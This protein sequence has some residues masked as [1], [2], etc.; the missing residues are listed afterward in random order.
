MIFTTL[1]DKKIPLVSIGTSPF[2]GAGQFGP[3]ALLWRQKFLNNPENVSDLLISSAENGGM[4]IEIVPVGRIAEAIAVVQKKFPNFTVTG[5]TYWEAPYRIDKLNDLDAEIIFIHGA[6]AD[7]RNSKE[8]RTIIQKIRGFNKIPGIATHNP[9][10]T[11]PFIQNSGL[12]C[13]A[14]LVP[15]NK[16]GFFMEHQK[17]LEDIVDNSDKFFV[18]MKSLAAGRIKPEEAYQYIKE[19]NI[20]AVAIG[21]VTKQEI[22]ESVLIALEKLST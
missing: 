8:L 20:S 7:R 18:A 5:S 9:T 4:G 19:H 16:L 13:P 22:E 1:E 14:I 2:M 11:I 17:I 12:D 21:M 3:N 10:K 15:F 6:I